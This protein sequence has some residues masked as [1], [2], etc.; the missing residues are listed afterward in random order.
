MPGIPI[1]DQLL[2]QQIFVFILLFVRIGAMVMVLPGLG[3]GYVTPRVRLCL[4]LALAFL[5]MAPLGPMI[6]ALPSD[7]GTLALLVGLEAMV[8][9]AIGT[10]ARLLLTGLNV[11]GNIIAMQTGLGFAI[12]VDP[13]QGAHGALLA[14]FLVTLGIL[15]IFITGAHAY[16]FGA[17]YRSYELFPPG[18]APS[19]ADFTELVVRFVSSSFALGVELSAPFLVLGLVFYAGL[20]VVSKLMPQFQVF[21]IAMPLSIMAGFGL[22]MVLIGVMMQVFL[23]RFAASFA[24]FAR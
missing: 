16:L 19:V 5:L 7:G 4:S 18:V 2:P 1:L 14:T 10:A 15:M 20:G 24:D 23:D 6:P 17:L 11:A 22:L 3:E 12:N 9:L 13:T 21:F 8:G